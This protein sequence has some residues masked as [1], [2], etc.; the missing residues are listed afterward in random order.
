MQYHITVSQCVKLKCILYNNNT[1]PQ[2]A[3]AQNH[4]K[5]VTGPLRGE[6]PNDKSIAS[7]TSNK[8]EAVD[9]TKR[10]VHHGLH[11]GK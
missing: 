7:K 10:V 8:E 5:D 6:N 2:D 3:P 4:F 1:V 9:K 11:L